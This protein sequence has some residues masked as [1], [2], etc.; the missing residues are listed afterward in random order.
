[1]DESRACVAQDA[2]NS[3]SG[4]GSDLWCTEVGF[5][6]YSARRWAHTWHGMAWLYGVVMLG[7]WDV[8]GRGEGRGSVG[9]GWGRLGS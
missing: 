8:G 1:M 5:W 9:L 6:V 2:G 4:L 3:M 7:L